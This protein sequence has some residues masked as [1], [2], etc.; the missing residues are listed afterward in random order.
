MKLK[1]FYPGVLILLVLFTSL[2]AGCINSGDEGG[3]E[4][5]YVEKVFY[6]EG[7]EYIEEG[8]TKEILSIF[9]NESTVLTEFTIRATWQDEDDIT[10]RRSYTNEPDTVQV[11]MEDKMGYHESGVG[12]NQHGKIGQ[13]IVNYPMDD[14]EN[15]RLEGARSFVISAEIMFAGDQEPDI[16]TSFGKIEDPGNKVQCN[17][18]WKTLTA[19]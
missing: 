19:A 11:F 17:C 12:E 14:F 5:E 15:N 8:Q 13:I 6:M 10:N 18:T 4:P 3:N 9:M 16:G 1:L 7:E 2:L